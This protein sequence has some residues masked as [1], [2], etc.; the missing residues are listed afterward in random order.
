MLNSPDQSNKERSWAIQGG[1]LLVFHILNAAVTLAGVLYAVLMI[2]CTLLLPLWI[3]HN[4]MFDTWYKASKY[5]FLRFPERSG[6]VSLGI[7]VFSCTS[8][9]VL[10]KLG[11]YTWI[12][13]PLAAG[14]VNRILVCYVLLPVIIPL[15]NADIR[16][17]QFIE[18]EL[19]HDATLRLLTEEDFKDFELPVT[20]EMDFFQ[21]LMNGMCRAWKVVLY[22]TFTK[23]LVG[24]RSASVVLLTT[25]LPVMMLISGGDAGF[26]ARFTENTFEIF[27]ATY[28]LWLV[29]AMDLIGVAFVSIKCTAHSSNNMTSTARDE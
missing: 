18:T 17:A 26:M 16:V 3:A 1:V 24:L 19:Q 20:V 11:W 15:V 5:V 8:S 14:G 25:I 12:L 10:D 7:F 9:Y 6:W 21:P 23:L 2:V 28:L 22:F 13:Y 4:L 27:V 29:G